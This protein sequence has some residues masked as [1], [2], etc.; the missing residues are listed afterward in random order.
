MTSRKSSAKECFVY[1]TLP[2][3]AEFVTAGR[4]VLETTRA[5]VPVGRFIYGKSYLANP[6]AV[7]IDPLGLKLGAATCSTTALKGVFGALRDAGPDHWGRRVIEKHSGKAKL[8]E[9]D[10]LLRAPDDR[11]GALGF[12]VGL[13]PPAPERKFNKTLDLEKLTMLAEAIIADEETPDSPEARQVK[14][15]MLIGTSMGGARP[16]TVVEDAEGLWVAKFN[17]P[18]D[19]WNHARVECA[20]LE[21]ANVCGLTASRSRVETVGGRDVLLVK[22]FDR[23]RTDQG[24]LRARM[25]SGLTVLRAEDTPTHRDRWS[26]VLFAEELRRICAEPEKDAVELFRRMV[27]NALISNTDD[28]PRNHAA[29]A[30]N[31]GW[32]LSPAYDLTPS[33]PVSLERRDL[34]MNCGDFGRYALAE[35][36]LSQCA[37]F[38][39]ERDQA[40]A[41]ID[42]M[43]QKIAHVWH[44]TARREGVS[45]KD[46]GTI[47]PAFTYPGFRLS[48]EYGA[49]V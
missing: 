23:E 49:E 13:K 31:T 33:V 42:A 14:D 19:Q 18:D 2:G 29:I 47:K 44:K 28:H 32:R 40:Q 39:L 22:R 48:L 8:D 24:Y 27:F 17:R 43:E 45:E 35:N 7:P 37:R 15:L 11:A 30:K 10:Y 46:C 25:I 6:D 38:C 5:G 3:T 1:I 9:I 12:G 20:M 21:L 41:L 36:L 4:F 34:A 26:Y 16:K